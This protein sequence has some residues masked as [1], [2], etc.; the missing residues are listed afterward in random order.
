MKTKESL[1]ILFLY[2]TIPGRCLLKVLVRPRFSRLAAKYLDTPFSRWLI[3]FYN[4]KHPPCGAFYEHTASPGLSA[5]QCQYR[6][7][8]AFFT[9]KRPRACQHIDWNPGHLISPCD[10]YLSIYPI[11]AGSTFRIKHITYSL[12]RLLQDEKLAAAYQGGT[13][14]I[15]RLAPHNYHRYCYPDHGLTTGRR[16][17]P[18]ILHCVRPAALETGPVLMQN[19]REY[20]TIQTDHFGTVVQ[21]EIGALLVGKICNH[22]GHT[23][24][25]RGMEKGYFAFGGSTIVLL[26]SKGIF[27]ADRRIMNNMALGQETP[28]TYGECI[29]HRRRIHAF[30]P[31]AFP[32]HLPKR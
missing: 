26:L 9:R 16:T 28:V 11:R 24:V 14:L 7:F 18:G 1:W 17:I 8:N 5:G 2:R 15:F 29:G 25:L 13:C 3:P 30:S 23:Y 22:P 6:S 27:T 10:G 4:R 19:A 12:T 21:M 20:V 32:F 31:M